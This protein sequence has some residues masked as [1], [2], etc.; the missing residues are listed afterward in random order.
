[1]PSKAR[2]P[3]RPRL[4][5]YALL[6]FCCLGAVRRKRLTTEE[7]ES[8]VPDLYRP[9]L[10]GGYYVAA[11]DPPRFGL[12]LIDAGG[13]GRWDRVLGRVRKQLEGHWRHPA[14]RSFIEQGRFEITILTLLPQKAQRLSAALAEWRDP[15]TQ[16]IRIAVLPELMH[17]I[18]PAPLQRR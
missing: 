13:R 2:S 1:M 17:L 16:F 14:L 6:A 8:H 7:I 11:G 4:R 15:R 12:A 10:P 18:A 3:S 9:G 5:A